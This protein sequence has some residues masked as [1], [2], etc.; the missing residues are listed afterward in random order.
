[1]GEDGQAA[2]EIVEKE[3]P[4]VNAIVLVGEEEGS[5]TFYSIVFLQLT[6]RAVS[7]IVCCGLFL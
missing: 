5:V 6:I 2:A 7:I 3:N 1:M 4:T